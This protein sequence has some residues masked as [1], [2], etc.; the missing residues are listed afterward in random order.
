LAAT[1]M[2]PPTKYPAQDANDPNWPKGGLIG[3]QQQLPSE[4]ALKKMIA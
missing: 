4:Q 1:M 2:I 3:Y